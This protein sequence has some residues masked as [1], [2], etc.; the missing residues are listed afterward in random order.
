MR[1]DVVVVGGGIVGLATAHR[2]LSERPDASVLVLEK[3]DA[4]AVHQTGHNSGVIHSGIYYEP[5]SL[6][7]RLCRAGAAATKRFT[8]EHGIAMRECGKLLVATDETELARL[9]ALTERAAANGIEAEVIDAAELRRREPAVA[10]LGALAIAGTAITD[11]VA[12]TRRLAEL[13]AAA[14][15]GEV[16]TGVEVVG[17]G[18]GAEAV[19]VRTATGAGTGSFTAE[20]VVFCAG[21]QA[22]RMARLCGIDVDF[23]IVPFRGEYFDVVPAKQDLVSTLIY[24]VPDPALPFLGVHLTPTVDGTLNVGPNAVLGLSREGYAKGSVRWADV[25][26]L[27]TFPGTWHVAR[28]HAATGVRELRSSLS[29]RGYLAL[30]RKYCPSLTLADLRPREAGI[31]AQAVLRDGSFV[32][33]FLLRRTARTLHVVNAPSPAATSAFPIA[34]MLAAEVGRLG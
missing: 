30:C 23:R 8:A 14:P 28:T 32:H 18:E 5:G 25:R 12:I 27:A 13:V 9:A 24:P 21:L 7:A 15:G 20:R 6:K 34:A 10:G 31:R 16:R 2:L 26:D 19:T 17:V 11:Y 29:K 3:E 22:D 1:Y 33:D 4:V